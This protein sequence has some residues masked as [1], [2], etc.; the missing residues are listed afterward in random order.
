MIP[1]TSDTVARP[2]DDDADLREGLKQERVAHCLERSQAVRVLAAAMSE[3]E[4][5]TALITVAE[6][7]EALARHTEGAP[8]HSPW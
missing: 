6:Q 7:W 5:R 1:S 3:T 8:T 4:C 2:G